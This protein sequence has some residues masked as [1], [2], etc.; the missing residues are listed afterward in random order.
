MNPS[1]IY[2]FLH[3]NKIVLGAFSGFAAAAAVDFRAFLSWKSE[4]DAASYDWKVAGWRWFQG[5]VA[6]AVTAA[7]LGLV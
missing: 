6:G 3:T 4:S 2:L 1:S 7:G 5:S